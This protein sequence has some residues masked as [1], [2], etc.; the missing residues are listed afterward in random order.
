MPDSIVTPRPHPIAPPAGYVPPAAAAFADDAGDCVLVSA[1]RPL[2]VTLA[3]APGDVPAALA[4]TTTTAV[5]AGPFAAVQDRPIMIEL[6]G[7]WQGTV[8]VQ[9][10]RDG[11]ATRTALTAG[12]LPWGRFTA[13]ACETV[14][15][16]TEAGV[17]FYL[18]IDLT[19]GTLTY[20][21]A[22]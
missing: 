19:A 2:P 10:S 3:A 14:W 15:Q 1:A 22:Q 20:R 7:Q 4:G 8:D 13:N 16:E 21:V 6:T 12:G 9:R 17:T 5:L 18:A 11:G